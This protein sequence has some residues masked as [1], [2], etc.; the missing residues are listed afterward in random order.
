[1]SAPTDGDP[2]ALRQGARRYG[3]ASRELFSASVDVGGLNQTLAEPFTFVGPAGD[4]FRQAVDV[5]GSSLRA[6]TSAFELVASALHDLAGPVE[7][8]LEAKKAL[9]KAERRLEEAEAALERAQAAADPGGILGS[10]LI[11]AALATEDATAAERRE[12]EEAKRHLT[13]ARERFQAAAQRKKAAVRRFVAACGDASSFAPA[14]PDKDVGP[15]GSSPAGKVFNALS[16]I[17]EKEW[18]IITNP[19]KIPGSVLNGLGDAAKGLVGG[20][21]FLGELVVENGAIT[22]A[23]G[24]DGDQD[25]TRQLGAAA[26]LAKEHPGEFAA[27]VA[28]LDG[29]KD[30]PIRWLAALAPELVT[31]AA[32][33]STSA[34]ASRTAGSLSKLEKGARQARGDAADAEAAAAAAAGPAARTRRAAEARRRMLDERGTPHAADP[35]LSQLNEALA[36]AQNQMVDGFAAARAARLRTA[37]AEALAGNARQ[38]A[39]GARAVHQETGAFARDEFNPF[40]GA[41]DPLNFT[42]PRVRQL[43]DAAN[44]ILGGTLGAVADP[45]LGQ[46]DAKP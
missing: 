20:A 11:G 12:L 6:A 2:D 41:M 23:L 15:F 3:N 33:G 44:K 30:D 32:T 7:D 1:M 46:D 40:F 42:D 18:E 28:N 34:V 17:G 24:I 36:L 39:D 10:L 31:A 4:R 13:R 38:R 19:H 25:K 29:L 5:A 45:T 26:S 22:R 9:E 21:S 27:A 37:R 14:L 35:R 8:V 43:Q 16:K